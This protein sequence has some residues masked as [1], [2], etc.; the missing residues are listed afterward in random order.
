MQDE[1]YLEDWVADSYIGSPTKNT[2][3]FYHSKTN[4]DIL[5]VSICKSTILNV[6]SLKS[7][8]N[9]IYIKDSEKHFKLFNAIRIY[10][11]SLKA[12]EYTYFGLTMKYLN[13]IITKLITH[14]KEFEISQIRK[15]IGE[16]Y[17]IPT[18]FNAFM[19]HFP[20][21]C[22]IIINP[23]IIRCH[24]TVCC[25]NTIRRR[26]YYR[27]QTQ[28][29]QDLNWKNFKQSQ[30]YELKLCKNDK[31]IWPH[32][33]TSKPIVLE[34]GHDISCIELKDSEVLND[35]ISQWDLHLLKLRV[36]FRD[37]KETGY[38]NVKQKHS[39]HIPSYHGRTGYGQ[40]LETNLTLWKLIEPIVSSLC[41]HSFVTN[42]DLA[43]QYIPRE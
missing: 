15:E 2:M 42:C 11:L 17:I 32:K 34:I 19:Y 25:P 8:F 4:T 12:D 14:S 3:H 6:P 27:I 29:S 13:Q 39:K 41:L 38:R 33:I 16:N 21:L 40:F 7:A 30:N 31:T 18:K 43:I 36:D 24:T 20:D 23:L 37:L 9:C 26:C 22:L 1:V 35:L 10:C 28:S 5:E